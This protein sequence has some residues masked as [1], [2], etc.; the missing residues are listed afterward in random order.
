VERPTGDVRA[1]LDAAVAAL[2]L[3]D[4]LADDGLAGRDRELEAGKEVVAEDLVAADE[5][6][7]VSVDDER[8]RR[9]RVGRTCC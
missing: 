8:M 2:G 6:A 5:E 7:A 1:L 4:D 9:R 3:A